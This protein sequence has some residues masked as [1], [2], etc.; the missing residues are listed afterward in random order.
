M[1]TQS[2]LLL[3][4][5]AAASLA[6]VWT[7]AG[8]SES[9]NMRFTPR[10]IA[11]AAVGLLGEAA[12]YG[13]APAEL[14]SDLSLPLLF[15]IA[16]V[17]ALSVGAA[18]LEAALAEKD[19]PRVIRRAAGIVAGTFFGMAAVGASS[20]DLSASS[21]GHARS[22]WALMFALVAATVVVFWQ[23]ARYAGAGLLALGQ[24][25]LIL[26]LVAVALLAGARLSVAASPAPKTNPPPAAVASV[27]EAAP[28]VA[29][30]PEAL[31]SAVPSSSGMPVPS[32]AAAASGAGVAGGAAV[33]SGAAAASAVPAPSGAASVPPVVGGQPGVI[34][35]ETIT[36]RGMLE[37][38]ARGGV[39]RRMER[40]QACLADPKNQ[41]SGSLTLKVGIDPSGSV[42]YSKAT[43]GDL[44]GTPL[45]TCLL[46][47]FYKMGF[48]APASGNAGFDI[49]LR[50]P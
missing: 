25:A 15:G 27:V 49:T 41:Q 2:M 37:A 13:R 33:P 42:G 1:S 29:A 17:V 46:P 8:F 48:A 18:K 43:G 34:Q 36:T 22:G 26:G 5:G 24:R 30:A 19:G 50:S 47:V 10:V 40:L 32:G 16:S 3:G 28:S 6:A 9:S 35:V 23:R 7:L 11:A 44:I 21:L 20:L 14:R 39:Q 31:A 4:A 12:A 45:A 38:D